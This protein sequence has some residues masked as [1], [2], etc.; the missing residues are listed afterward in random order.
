MVVLVVVVAAG[1]VVIVSRGSSGS[2]SSGSSSLSVVVAVLAALEYPHLPANL[3]LGVDHNGTR[4]HSAGSSLVDAFNWEC[5]S[6]QASSTWRC[7][8][9]AIRKGTRTQIMEFLGPKYH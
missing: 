3:A 4:G 5:E 1:A 7:S 9:E 8:W 6:S 2:S